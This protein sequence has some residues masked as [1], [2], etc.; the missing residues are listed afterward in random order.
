MIGKN[1]GFEDVTVQ[2]WN[3]KAYKIK[4]LVKAEAYLGTQ[5]V[6]RINFSQ[7]IWINDEIDWFIKQYLPTVKSSMMGDIEP[8]VIKEL[9][10]YSILSYRDF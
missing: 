6:D 8:G 3:F 5:V 4:I 1:D 2:A 10:F 7:Y 9:C